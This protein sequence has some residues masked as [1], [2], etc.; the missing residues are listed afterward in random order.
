MKE[1]IMRISIT[2]LTI[3]CTTILALGGYSSHATAQM[4][5]FDDFED[6]VKDQALLENNWTWYDQT[7][8]ADTCTGPAAGFGPYDDGD[9]SDYV[10]QN[11]NYWTASDD[12]GEGNSYFRAGLEVPAWSTD[13]GDAVLLTNMLRV[14]GNQYNEATT[15]QRTSIFQEMPVTTAGTYTFSFDVA[16]DRVG[17][18]ANGE[19]TGAFVKVL[20]SS[21]SSFVDLIYEVVETIPPSASTP[22]DV[23]T[24]TQSIDFV[25]PEEMVGELL[26]IGFYSDLTPNFGQSW[27]TSAALYDNVKLSLM[28]IG[29][30]H[31]GSWFNASQDGHGWALLFGETG[32]GDPL[33]VAY[34]YIYDDMGNPIFL[35]GTGTPVGNRVEITLTASVG[36]IYGVFDPDS[37]TRHPGGT[38]V[39]E[40]SDR[41][42]SIF[43]YVPSEFTMNTWGHTPIV[44]LPM[45]KLFGLPAEKIYG[46]SD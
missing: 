44:D 35:V 21:D 14:Y 16:Q 27:T 36:M 1:F 34:W 8:A 31:S 12:V 3:L 40:F 15:C 22:N 20:R 2:Y 43:S 23:T 4:S 25:I 10:A 45:A 26:Q 6:R 24:A 13:E 42:T 39:F 37:V 18:P 11:R 46:T 33:L 19:Y 7:F 32:S 17:A 28:E 38:A 5:F 41:N 9:A 29:P 30:A